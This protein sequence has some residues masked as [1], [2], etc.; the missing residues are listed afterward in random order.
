[1]YSLS[2]ANS[3][4]RQTSKAELFRKIVNGFSSLTIFVKSSITDWVLNTPL[5]IASH[6]LLSE[7]A[8]Q[9]TYSLIEL[10]KCNHHNFP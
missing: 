2:E 7:K 9:L 10:L 4:P 6:Y 5:Q 3:E 8:K 1:M